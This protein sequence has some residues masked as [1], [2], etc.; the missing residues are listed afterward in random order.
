MEYNPYWR[1]EYVDELAQLEGA[2]AYAMGVDVTD[3]AAWLRGRR[4]RSL[5]AIGAGGSLAVA[6][7]AAHLHH[8]ATGRL[9]RAGEPMDLFMISPEASAD[10]AGLLVT[11][12]GGHSDSLRACEHL[13]ETAIDAA[14][15]CGREASRGADILEGSRTP[16]FAYD[17]LPEVHG[18]VAVNALLGQAV[19]LARAYAQAFPDTLGTVPTTLRSLLPEGASTPQEALEKMVSR[20]GDALARRTLIFLYGPD[21]KAAA[22]DLDSKFAES[23]LGSLDVSEYR[24]FAHGRYQMVLPEPDAFGIVAF[25]SQSEEPIA[26]ATFDEI[27]E[28]LANG[29]IALTGDGIAAE[30]LS[31]LVALLVLVGAIGE[32][33]SLRPGWGVADAFGDILYQLDLEQLF[34]TRSAVAKR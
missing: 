6:Q 4:D 29:T 12:S 19:V 23:G 16:V 17:L 26:T 28:E 18:W 27:P 33:R 22:V 11:A 31:S 10:T 7:M 25:V 5:L 13:R 24:N 2:Y 1:I 20:L 34:P 21:T 30:Q 14:V 15:F 32:V 8:L 9:T 3:F